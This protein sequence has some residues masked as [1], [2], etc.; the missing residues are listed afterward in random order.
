MNMHVH[1]WPLYSAAK[2][3]GLEFH[4][5]GVSFRPQIP[6]PQY[7]FSSPLLGF[8][9]TPDGVYSGWYAPAVSSSCEITIELP[10][11]DASHIR[12]VTINGVTEDVTC[13]K[14]TFLLS[15]QIAPRSPLRWEIR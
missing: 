5:R 13:T 15:G 9:K 1:A 10:E 6:L 3:L 11:A 4:E 7:E 14:L 12:Y 2:L 8:T